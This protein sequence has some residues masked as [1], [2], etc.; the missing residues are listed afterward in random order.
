MG[1]P[2][3]HQQLLPTPDSLDSTPL[4]PSV[5]SSSR[6]LEASVHSFPQSMPTP[7]RALRTPA[8]VSVSEQWERLLL[9]TV[10]L[11]R[12]VTSPSGQALV[13]LLTPM[14]RSFPSL[15][16]PPRLAMEEEALE[17]LSQA[18]SSL[19]ATARAASEASLPAA[20]TMATLTGSV[21]APRQAS[22][23]ARTL[24]AASMPQ[25]SLEATSRRPSLPVFSSTD[26]TQPLE[27]NPPFS[28][29]AAPT[30]TSSAVDQVFLFM[31]PSYLSQNTQVGIYD[32]KQ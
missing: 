25:L 19:T 9:A 24:R 6:S 2:L 11:A 5:L 30:S 28:D 3:V 23:S 1:L 4:P 10:S 17:Q 22:A 31:K 16:G 8:L 26:Q 32:N 12:T 20:S 13:L 14:D 7:T 15:E 29:R 18:E 27:S 21:L